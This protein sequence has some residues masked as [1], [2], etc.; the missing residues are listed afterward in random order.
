MRK[1]GWT[2]LLVTALLASNAHAESNYPSKPI[3]LVVAFAPGGGTDT[4]ARLVAKDLATE[5]G[6]PVIVENRP[7]A[8][9]AIGAVGV[10]R[11]AADGYTLLFGS[12]SEL[13]VLTAVKVKAPYDPLKDFTPITEVGT[14]SFVLAASPSL[15]TT[16]VGELIAYA[17]A[18]P[19]KLNFASFG[20]GS[21][22]HLIGEAFARKN[23]LSL[24]HVPYKGSAAAVTDLLAGQVQ[25]AFDTA[26][27]M[28][29]LIRSGSLKGL[30]TLSPE[31]TPLAPELPTMAESGLPDF[32][33]EGWLGVLAPRG[34]PSAIVERLHAALVKVLRI[35]ANVETLQ[36]RG[37]KVVASTPAEF[38]AFMQA[39]VAKWGEIA[40]AADIKIE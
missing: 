15:N 40:R 14:V 24:V 6:Q 38:G 29:P 12:G 33:F 21:T 34:T 35:P 9:G 18:N 37:V 19:G 25:L 28:I 30:A 1:L 17:R 22:N 20:I 8:G 5:L 13:D 10:T 32:T 26:S 27:V 11:A 31:R 2:A 39:D 16:S 7:G 36:Q 23:H 4:A 3:T